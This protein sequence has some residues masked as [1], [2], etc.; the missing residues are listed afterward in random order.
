MNRFFDQRQAP[1][2]L[3]IAGAG[4]AFVGLAVAAFVV[5][6]GPSDNASGAAQFRYYVLH[7]NGIEVQVL[8]FGLASMFMIAFFAL[9]AGRIRA[10]GQEAI[11]LTYAMVAGAATTVVVYSISIATL[12]V[13]AHCGCDPNTDIGE[14]K[15]LSFLLFRDLSDKTGIFANFPAAFTIAA[16]SIGILWLAPIHRAAGW[17]GLVLTAMLLAAGAVQVLSR[18]SG[19]TLGDFAFFGFLLWT[20]LC[21]GLLAMQPSEVPQDTPSAAASLSAP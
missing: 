15:T 6:L 14:E 1:A 10:F 9:F 20:L 12:L 3:L 7:H 16:S 17:L 8:L 2:R 18:D 13:I 19:G 4:A 5:D 21:S 11:P